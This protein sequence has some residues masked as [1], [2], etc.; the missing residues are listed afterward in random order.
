MISFQPVPSS[1]SAQPIPAAL[2]PP[3]QSL[4][5]TPMDGSTA[6]A[7]NGALLA[8]GGGDYSGRSAIYMY[9]A[10]YYPGS[11]KDWVVWRIINNCWR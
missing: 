2:P 1:A 4:P 9:N 5:N 11:I 7:V 6:L 3:W 10:M 8:I